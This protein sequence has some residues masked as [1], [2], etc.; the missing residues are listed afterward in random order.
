MYKKEVNAQSPL[1]I[2]ERSIHGGLGAGNL[3]VVMARAG[4]GKTAFL[5]QIGLDDAMRDR[6]V[7][8]IALGQT[9]EH[10]QSWYDGLFDDLAR[11]TK[12]EH[13][14]QVRVNFSRRRVIQASSEM[15]ISPAQLE[16]T[17]RLYQ[18]H[19]EFAPKAILIDGYHWDDDVVLQAADI[20]AFKA[21][22]RRLG[23]ELWMTAQTHRSDT[24]QHPTKMC[25][26]CNQF[27]KLIDVGVFLEPH[28]HMVRVRLLKDH[29]NPDVEVTHLELEPD[30]LQLVTDDEVATPATLPAQ[31][32][33]LLSGA[34]NGAEAEF[35]ACAEKYGIAEMNY[36]FAGRSVARERGVV[37]L[38]DAELHQGEASS[39]YIEAHLHRKFP[40]TPQFRK[41]LQT[42]WHQVATSG[43][44]FVVGVILDDGTVN[45]GTG[46]AAELAKHFKKPLFVYDQEKR[47]WFGWNNDKFS[48]AEAPRIDRRRFTGTGTRFLSDEGRKAIRELFARSFG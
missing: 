34:N 30:T 42:I 36:S 18:Q 14:E 1:R 22:A 29:D 20:G 8:H 13:R 47:A 7:L 27:E 16:E 41:M 39:A 44:V 24:G 12:L 43:Q 26:P 3:G 32:Y 48:E 45:G 46:W 11:D 38:S 40:K 15:T 31:A 33:T 17:V 2:L 6:D 4:V 23:A 9:L 21:L 37:I 5:V 25:A 19:A 28:E 10:A 35:G